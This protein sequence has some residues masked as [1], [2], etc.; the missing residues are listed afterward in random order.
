MTVTVTIPTALSMK[1]RF[2]EFADVDDSVLEFAIEEARLGVR[3]NWTTGYN[4]AIMYL[5]AHY[6]AASIA[7][8]I[9]GGLGGEVEIASESYG[10][11]SITYAQPQN[12]NAVHSD[13]STSSYGQR[14]DALVERNFGGPRII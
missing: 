14:Y 10:R 8:S 3:T 12:A 7:A 1:L 11:F 5:A 6:V 9:S 13:T 4:I 2:P